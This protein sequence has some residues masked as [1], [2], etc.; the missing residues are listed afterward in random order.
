[1]NHHFSRI[2]YRVLLLYQKLTII[3]FYYLHLPVC[4]WKM[5]LK[6]CYYTHVGLK[7]GFVNSLSV[8]KSLKKTVLKKYDQI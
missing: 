2:N 7:Y 8:Y 6:W 5:S 4:I 1:M 3:N